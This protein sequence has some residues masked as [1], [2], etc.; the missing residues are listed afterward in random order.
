MSP[1]AT[2]KT[3]FNKP[4][5]KKLSILIYKKGRQIPIIN[6]EICKIL[7]VSL[8]NFKNKNGVKNLIRG[9]I[10]NIIPICMGV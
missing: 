6:K 4:K 10:E 9:A 7:F 2:P 1:D 3:I 8:N 5:R